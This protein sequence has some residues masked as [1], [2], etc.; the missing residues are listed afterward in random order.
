MMKAWRGQGRRWLRWLGWPLLGSLGVAVLTAGFYL[1]TVRPARHELDALQRNLTELRAQRRLVTAQSARQ[2]PR[3]QLVSFYQT[4]P[5]AASAPDLLERI[6]VAALDH[7]LEL[8]KGDYRIIH[9]GQAQLDQYQLTLPLKG[10]YPDIRGFLDELL[11]A[12]PTASLDHVA[13]ERQKIGETAVQVTVR[14]TLYLRG[15]P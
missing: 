12:L 9:N 8:I 13:F 7:H 11:A 4:F 1:T 5:A 15:G 2:S 6:Y 14:V 3:L 10:R